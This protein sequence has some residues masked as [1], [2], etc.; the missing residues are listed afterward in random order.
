MRVAALVTLAGVSVSIAA[1]S[2]ADTTPNLGGSSSTSSTPAASAIPRA[3]VERDLKLEITKRTTESV[4]HEREA[5]IDVW[6]VNRSATASYP[7][8]LSNDGSEMGWREPHA[9]YVVERM[10]PSGT[11]EPLPV[12]E[13]LRCGVYAE[14]WTK[15]MRI[16]APG[17]R[18][19][20]PSMPYPW[21][22][23]L[24]DATRVRITA[25]YEYGEHARDKSKVPVP[26]H[27][28]PEYALVSAPIEIPVEHPYE[29]TLKLKGPLP[30][31]PAAPL[32]AALDVVV[33]NRS[34]RALPVGDAESGASLVF[35][36]KLAS[37]E[38]TTLHVETVPTYP[39]RERLGAGDRAAL[40]T[41]QTRTE[42]LWTLPSDRIVQLRAVW[43]IYDDANGTHDQRRVD[44]P[45]V[46]VK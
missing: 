33:Q 9:F 41:A 15:D 36:A 2:G 1:C 39:S 42:S 16:L 14:D 44:S 34:T 6:L 37:G 29:L 45:W 17:E 21:Y 27:A 3:T 10:R 11:W 35:E 26:L 31:T 40:V 5:P 38:I 19:K 4:D 22:G 28:M 20:L 7:I 25:R 43:R 12:G 8:V 18:V 32:A 23:M 24:E 13:V 46:D 30:A